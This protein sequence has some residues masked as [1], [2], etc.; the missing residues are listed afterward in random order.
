MLPN[1]NTDDAYNVP[2]KGLNEEFC[3]YLLRLRCDVVEI[4]LRFRYDFVA[5]SLRFRYEI[6]TISSAVAMHFSNKETKGMK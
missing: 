4:S 3:V 1:N 5:M 2:I 6:L